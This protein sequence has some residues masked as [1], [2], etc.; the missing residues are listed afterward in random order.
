MLLLAL[1]SVV[2]PDVPYHRRVLGGTL[3]KRRS[4]GFV[5]DFLDAFLILFLIFWDCFGIFG[6]IGTAMG[7]YS[8]RSP[9]CPGW[10][11]RKLFE[12]VV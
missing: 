9:F 5:F 7:K 2:E 1:L 4:K 10:L 6:R 11:V 12:K 3:S 8:P